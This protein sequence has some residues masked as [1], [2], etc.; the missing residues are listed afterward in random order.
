MAP[1]EACVASEVVILQPLVAY[2][3]QCRASAP[4]SAIAQFSELE[5]I[6]TLQIANIPII[7]NGAHGLCVLIGYNQPWLLWLLLLLFIIH[8][9][10]AQR[11]QSIFISYNYRFWCQMRD[12][13][14][15]F[16]YRID[17][18]LDISGIAGIPVTHAAPTHP[19]DRHARTHTRTHKHGNE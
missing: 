16:H 7:D 1:D 9:Q 8:C 4:L 19:T 18:L 17:V 13:G 15:Y 3:G 11:T 6:S 14:Q 5:F 12:F 10:S 2:W